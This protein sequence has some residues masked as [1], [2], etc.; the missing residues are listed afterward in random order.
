MQHDITTSSPQFETVTQED[1]DGIL[2]RAL[3]VLAL[4]TYPYGEAED[5][6][7]MVHLWVEVDTDDP[8]LAPL[9]DAMQLAIREDEVF[10]MKHAVIADFRHTVI[11]LETFVQVWWDMTFLRDG[12]E[13]ARFSL[14]LVLPIQA[15]HVAALAE[16]GFLTIC[17]IPSD[18]ALAARLKKQQADATSEAAAQGLPLPA[19]PLP[20]HYNFPPDSETVMMV[21]GFMIEVADPDHLIDIVI[22]YYELAGVPVEVHGIQSGL[23]YSRQGTD[24]TGVSWD[25]ILRNGDI[26][27]SQAR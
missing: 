27:F 11:T 5:D 24:G 6:R 20:L 15:M 3:P 18:S 26:P 22:L 9:H 2:A 23:G 8:A 17:P 14:P 4:T 7:A 1:F 13:V 16:E 10:E 19:Y 21:E 12:L 25:D